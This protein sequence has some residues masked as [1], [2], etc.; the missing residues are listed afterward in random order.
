MQ[1]LVEVN[2]SYNLHKLNLITKT[3]EKQQESQHIGCRDCVVCV[4][5][6][7]QKGRWRQLKKKTEQKTCRSRCLVNAL[8]EHFHCSFSVL[9]G[10]KIHFCSSCLPHRCPVRLLNTSKGPSIG[11]PPTHVFDR[12][13]DIHIY[14]SALAS[15]HTQV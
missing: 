13:S 4:A 10:L 1:L 14:V 9:Q 11:S 2:L 8:Q 15:S 3:T 7:A 12:S 6:W 5:N